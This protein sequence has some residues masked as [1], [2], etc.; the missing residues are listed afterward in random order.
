MLTQSFDAVVIGAGSVG[1]PT[2]CFLADA[3][4]STLV[5]DQFAGPGQGSNKAAI[6]GIR[7]THS[8][9]AKI[10]LC[11]DS[12]RIF[13]TWEQVN[14]DCIEWAQGG[15]AFVAYREQEERSLKELLKIQHSYGLNIRWLDRQELLDLSPGLNP[16]HL[17]GGTYSPEDGSGSPLLSACAFHA[18]AARR[19]VQ[20]RFGERVTG[21]IRRRGKVVG[22]RTDK[23][24][25]AT[26][27]VV[28]AGGAWARAV[29]QT[30][31]LDVPVVPDSHEAGITEPVAP[32]LV[33][34]VVD[35]R[36][37]DG[38]R[39]YY[40]YQHRP[41][42]VVFCITPDPPIVGTDRR[43]TSA[44]L[45]MI[46]RRMVGLIPRL[47]NIKVRRTWRGLYPMTPDGSPII[48]WAQEPEGYLNAV[49][50]CGQGYMLGPGVGALISRMVQ[51]KTT[52]EDDQI[53][54]ELRSDR[55]FGG[56]EALK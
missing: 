40:F 20:F 50:M 45:P 22:V 16:N 28:N 41:G 13:S 46:A 10:R 8:T 43:E 29:A 44:Y 55:D 34:M 38:S 11:L 48:G 24:G 9:P 53:L 26:S 31:G 19:G 14:G 51:R 12:I 42:G 56:V 25:Y 47:A 7:A 54:Q 37:V 23:G 2:A 18:Q 49:G 21:I 52:A 33:P 15:Y 36:P 32:F 27:T 39:N 30:A 35:I 4:L 6:G 17:R 5:V 3:G 1:L